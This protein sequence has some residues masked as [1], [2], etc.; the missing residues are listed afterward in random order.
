[1]TIPVYFF[2]YTQQI[3]NFN[4]YRQDFRNNEILWKF[5]KSLKAQQQQEQEQK[6]KQKQQQQQ[7]HS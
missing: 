5:Y 3:S 7:S 6:Q 1:M 4:K 2:Q